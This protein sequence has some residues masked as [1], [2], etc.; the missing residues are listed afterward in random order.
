MYELHHELPNDLRLR[1]LGYLEILRKSLKFLGLFMC[2]YL[3]VHPKAKLWDFLVKNCK[4]SA[5]KHSKEKSILLN[6]VNLSPAFCSRLYVSCNH[7]NESLLLTNCVELCTYKICVNLLHDFD[8]IVNIEISNY[9]QLHETFTCYAIANI[10]CIIS[11]TVEDIW[12][13]TL[14]GYWQFVRYK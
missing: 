1:I 13:N 14:K 10:F 12:N 5:V 4:K 6:F 3:A 7:V 9:K 11:L 8:A 2:E